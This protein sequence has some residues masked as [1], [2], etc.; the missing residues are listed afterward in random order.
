L[1]VFSSLF[2]AQRDAVAFLQTSKVVV[3]SL[4]V[5][6]SLGLSPRWAAPAGHKKRGK[7]KLSPL[8]DEEEVTQ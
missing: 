6:S 5:F 2:F 1:L 3:T 7:L 8:G 4:L